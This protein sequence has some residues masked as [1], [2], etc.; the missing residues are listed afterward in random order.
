[1]TT[2]VWIHGHK[3]NVICWDTMLS[4]FK[5][6]KNV[7]QTYHSENGFFYNIANM[8]R[9]LSKI[10]DDIVIISHSLGGIYALHLLEHLDNIIGVVS[11]SAPFGG[12]D[13]AAVLG[14]FSCDQIY[15]DIA[16]YSSPIYMG[17]KIMIEVPWLAL[18]SVSGNNYIIP[19]RNDGIVTI[20]SMTQRNDVVYKEFMTDHFG[21][22]ENKQVILEID[23]FMNLLNEIYTV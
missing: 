2:I 8:V 11:M 13:T 3:A 10:E 5:D 12:S 14:L 17:H 21:I 6:Y 19:N 22:L 4:H 23:K 16:P 7:H 9:D 1:M 18:V 20:N 15:K